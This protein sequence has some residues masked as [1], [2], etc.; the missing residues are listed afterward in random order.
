MTESSKKQEELADRIAERL[1]DVL[2][3]PKAI[4]KIRNSHIVSALIGA[5]G[6]ALFFSGVEKVFGILSGGA[7]VVVGLILLALSGALFSKLN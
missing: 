1:I 4:Q 3:K 6:L 7:S 2:G 5:V